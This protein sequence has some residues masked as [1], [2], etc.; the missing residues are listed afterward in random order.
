MKKISEMTEIIHGWTG[1]KECEGQSR[2]LSGSGPAC[3]EEWER[4]GVPAVLS[5]SK[6]WLVTRHPVPGSHKQNF[7]ENRGAKGKL[8]GGR[9]IRMSLNIIKPTCINDVACVFGS[10][11][12]V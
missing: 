8:F 5:D 4:D 10:P 12:A 6:M 11:V 3:M 2:V 7:S 1:D 9:K